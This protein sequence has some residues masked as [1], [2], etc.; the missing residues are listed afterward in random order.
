MD[1]IPWAEFEA[2][3]QHYLGAAIVAALLYIHVTQLPDDTL[4][5]VT[6]DSNTL[7]EFMFGDRSEQVLS[8]YSFDETY[9][10]RLKQALVQALEYT[11]FRGRRRSS[12]YVSA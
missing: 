2:S 5:A 12:V 6:K 7:S 11:Q 4:D 9:R 10:R 8:T 1:L 3:V